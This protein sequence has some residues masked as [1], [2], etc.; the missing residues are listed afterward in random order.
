[1]LDDS[2]QHPPSGDGQEALN[3]IPLENVPGIMSRFFQEELAHLSDKK[4]Q[5]KRYAK[6]LVDTLWQTAI[7]PYLSVDPRNVE[8]AVHRQESIRTLLWG[9]GL[10]AFLHF[11]VPV[12]LPG[13]EAFVGQVEPALEVAFIERNHSGTR[14][15]SRRTAQGVKS[16]LME[17]VRNIFP[18]KTPTRED[19]KSKERKDR[20]AQSRY[21][22]YVKEK[23]MG[24]LENVGLWSFEQ[25]EETTK[26]GKKTTRFEI[27]AG[28]AL[29]AFSLLVYVPIAQR[30]NKF[31]GELAL[32]GEQS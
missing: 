20:A 28:P 23:V 31:Y 26:R 8:L 4:E 30:Q 14:L 2:R 21:R 16:C 27:E 12:M 19:A 3:I 6:K 7:N 17:L 25:I 9:H 15:I 24:L 5:E 18:P 1:V 22:R 10:P 32:L 11:Y 13:G 29:R